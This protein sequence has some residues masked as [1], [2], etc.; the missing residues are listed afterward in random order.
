MPGSGPDG[1]PIIL[2]S[3][4]F[5][6]EFRPFETFINN[7]QATR[8][9]TLD[10]KT[11]SLYIHD[12]WALSRNFSFDLGLRYERVR[13]EATGGILGVDTD[14][15]V[16][17]LAATWDPTGD[18]SWVLQTTYAHYAGKYSEAQ[19]ASNTNVGSPDLVQLLYLGPSGDGFG[20]A[21]GFD[22]DNYEAVDGSFNSANVS[23]EDGLSSPVNKE[24]TAAVGRQYK[25]G[26][27]KAQYVRR[28]LT[29]IVEDFRDLTTGATAVERDG[30]EYGPF[31]N[32]VYRNT[33]L[34]TRE[35]R[36]PGVHGQPPLQ[37][38]LVGERALDGAVE[39]R[40]QLR[41]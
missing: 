32:S 28:R 3:G 6:P 23:F 22:L 41:G 38:T 30:V 27:V 17:R 8:G 7:W 20:F 34:D 31:T 5:V 40:R 29:N 12:K 10:I 4:K 35:Y 18:G 24:F 1:T 26:Y 14:T 21:P 2:P 9:A 13:S 39:E 37:L 33:D 11:T 15:I 19:F 36:R 25:G 16:P